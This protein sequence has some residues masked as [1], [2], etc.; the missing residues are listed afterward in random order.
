MQFRAAQKSAVN[1][2]PDDAGRM[3]CLLNN[4]IIHDDL[5]IDD[6]FCSDQHNPE[7]QAADLIAPTSLLT[8]N[9]LSNRLQHG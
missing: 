7:Y 9:M 4:Q 2:D 1:T 6:Q 8:I 5:F 3:K